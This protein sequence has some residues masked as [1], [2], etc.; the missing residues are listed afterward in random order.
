MKKWNVKNKISSDTYSKK[1]II[2][3]L[4]R[5]RGIT[6]KQ[7]IEDFFHPK[8]PVFLTSED[9]GI[10]ALSMQAFIKRVREAIGGKESIVVYA[11]YDAD[12]I[13]AG[14]TL[15]EALYEL[16]AHVMP[17]IPNRREEGYG[18]SKKGL[19]AVKEKY[20]PTL[21]ISV[22]HGITARDCVIF[23][24]ELGM[25]IIVSDHHIKPD[26]LPECLLLHTAILSG[27]GIAFFLASQL[28][29]SYDKPDDY[30]RNLLP[31]PTIGTIA[32]MVPLVGP[33]RSI[34]KYGLMELNKTKRVGLLSLIKNAGLTERA[35]STY[36]ISHMLAPRIN[37]M[38]RLTH[39]MDALR[40]LCTKNE[41]RADAL[42]QVLGSTNTKRQEMTVDTVLHAK[43]EVI[44][45]YGDNPAKR[46]L[47]VGHESYDQGIIGLVAGRLMEEQYRPVIVLSV[48]ETVSK[49]SA[50]S[51]QGF[52][53]IEA[54]RS[55][56]DLLIDAGGHPL[57]AGFT[58]ETKNI[59]LFKKK[60]EEYAE[61]HVLDEMLSRS[62]TVDMEIPLSVLSDSVWEG[63][64]DFEPYG[65]G[66][67]YPVFAS[68]GVKVSD[69]RRIGKDQKHVKMKVA[70]LSNAKNIS[71]IDA[72]AF[73]QA[74]AFSDIKSQQSVDICFTVDMN[75][76]NGKKSMQLKIQD[77]IALV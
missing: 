22:D 18:F 33:N 32:D 15:W 7:D 67:P 50:R 60:I 73:H 3:T 42:A 57:A 9:V 43:N 17:Y 52:N 61:V 59:E 11:D 47:V 2:D 21:I 30:I 27:S 34:V 23:A 68:R 71:S 13:T 56:Q 20:N 74:E 49:A 51:I 25:E 63:L 53:I 62:L 37:A 28:F 65:L 10:D 40:L 48:G 38:G 35:L 31:F 29:H 54:I 16:G 66:N 76:W 72:I 24:K 77:V 6:S 55:F 5:E 58:I 44:R 4:L 36:T 45:V 70:V 26:H 75:E 64:Q 12:G 46:I 1:T 19:L 41:N 39:A 8:D 14:A 69:I